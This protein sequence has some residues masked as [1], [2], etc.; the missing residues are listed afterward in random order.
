MPPA[1]TMPLPKVAPRFHLDQP[2]ALLLF[3]RQLGPFSE[4]ENVNV[5]VARKDLMPSHT[6]YEAKGWMK[7]VRAQHH[8]WREVTCCL[9]VARVAR[10]TNED[11]FNARLRSRLE[12][13]LKAC[14]RGRP[15]SKSFFGVQRG[16]Q[17]KGRAGSGSRNT[18]SLSLCGRR[19]GASH[20][21]ACP[22]HGCL[23]GATRGRIHSGKRK[24]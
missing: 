3:R 6:R 21:Q 24:V 10:N 19:G 17:K 4:N 5:L 2:S 1:T 12:A 18:L 13:P 23:A 20:C 14:C 8:A 22:S 11:A 16:K 9:C 7:S 15:S